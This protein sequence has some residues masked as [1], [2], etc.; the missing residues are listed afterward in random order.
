MSRAR[1]LAAW[2]RARPGTL[3]IVALGI[4]WGTTMHSMGWAQLGHFA[5]VRALA[6]GEPTID[7]WHWETGDV[8]WI[9]GHY[10]S[11]KSPGT[12]ALAVP[13]YLAIDAGGRGAA[14]AAAENASEA[15]HPRWTPNDEWPYRQYGYD[16]DRALRVESRNEANTPV[17]WAL[18]LLAAVIPSVLLLVMVRSIAERLE[19]GY[20][21]AAAITLGL[22]TILMVFAAE[23]FSH[24]VS[25]TLGFAAFV[26]L[27][28][29]RAGPPRLALV[30]AAGLLAGLAITFEYQ[31]GLVAVILV[32]YAAWRSS[33]VRR[34]F[35]YAGAALAGVLPVLAYN[36]WTLGSPFK[37]AYGDAVSVI[38]S[39]GHE[40]VGLNDDGFF[41]ITLPRLDAA[42]DLLVGGR[43]LLVLTPVL[44]LAAIGVVLMYRRGHRAEALTIGA[45]ATAYFLYD[46]GY[47]QPYGGGTPGPRF[48]IP[49]LPFLALGLAFAYRRLPATTL[50]LAVPSA[51]CMLAASLTHPLIG[52]QGTGLWVDWLVDGRL[53]HTLLTALGVHPSWPAA[54]PVL[55]CVALAARLAVAATP[56]TT[57]TDRDLTYAVAALAGWIAVATLGPS[58]SDDP[59]T[60]LTGDPS[61]LWLIAVRALASAVALLVMLR[62]RPHE[63]A[64]PA[65]TVRHP[66]AFS[67][68]SS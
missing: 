43:G 41:G 36:A 32:A 24:A 11:V 49:M 42:I 31:L 15:H 1:G 39:S 44:V 29:E 57:I 18:T 9:D 12:A 56:R 6:N 54:I 62:H 28:R 61:A 58:I 3:A 30:A 52:E 8:A 20:G 60:P 25:A 14:R 66:L 46:S 65:A 19:P 16:R 50:A 64:E 63:Q 53:E 10:Y 48:L 45:V 4:A 38:G 13:L 5:E 7:R 40:Q 23:L 59:V 26:V 17:V 51:L 33:P 34:G 21:T 67:D 22:G 55:L 2:A 27:A 37:L 68:Q 47:W 35:A